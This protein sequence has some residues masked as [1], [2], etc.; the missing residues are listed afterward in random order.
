[1]YVLRWERGATSEKIVHARRYAMSCTGIPCH[2]VPLPFGSITLAGNTLRVLRDVRAAL[3]L[4]S[5]VLSHL[6]KNFIRT[7]QVPP[8][9]FWRSTTYTPC[10]ISAVVRL[11]IPLIPLYVSAVPLTVWG[12]RHPAWRGLSTVRLARLATG[13][14]L[15]HTDRHSAGC[16]QIQ[17]ESLRPAA[18]YQRGYQ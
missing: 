4:A 7:T 6:L 12:A 9:C 8:G 5:R 3:R 2:V 1:M 11:G 15:C 14:Q 17:T 16:T 18:L 10:D 13:D